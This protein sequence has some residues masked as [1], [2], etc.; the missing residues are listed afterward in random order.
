MHADSSNGAANKEAFE[1]FWQVY[2]RQEGK[3]GAE[4]EF[5]KVLEL[6]T[7]EKIIDAARQYAAL[8]AAAIQG[9][10]PPRF[11]L[12]PTRWLAD[13]HWANPTNGMV[14]EQHGNSVAMPT[15]RPGDDI[16]AEVDAILATGFRINSGKKD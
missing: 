2:P 5:K 8:R 3:R 1:R 4:R 13:G 14:I 15:A 6:S 7:A 16:D 12:G 9:G 10:D 11:T